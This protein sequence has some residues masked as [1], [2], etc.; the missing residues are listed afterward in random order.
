MAQMSVSEVMNISDSQKSA[1]VT[2][3]TK[4]EWVNGGDIDAV[5]YVA[6]CEGKVKKITEYADLAKTMVAS[7]STFKYQDI[8]NPTKATEIISELG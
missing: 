5:N 3:I 2:P 6:G 1:K 8:L 4:F 7:I